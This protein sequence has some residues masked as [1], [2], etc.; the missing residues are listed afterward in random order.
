MHFL[1]N[2][3]LIQMVVEEINILT[4]VFLKYDNQKI[5]FPNYILNTKPIYNF[6]RSPDMG[7]AIELCFHVATPGEKIALMRQRIT[8]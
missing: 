3:F 7:D 5:F 6:Y 2:F 8:R 4:T 1:S